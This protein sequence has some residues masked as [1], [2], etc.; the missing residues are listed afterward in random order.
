MIKAL[1]ILGYKGENGGA[2]NVVNEHTHM[3]IREMAAL[4]SEKIAKGKIKVVFD[5]PESALKYG[6]APSVKMKLSNAKMCALG[7]APEVDL[8]EMYERMMADMSMGE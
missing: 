1:L 8:P 4:V 6:Y 2:Y 5:I 3:Q 7:W